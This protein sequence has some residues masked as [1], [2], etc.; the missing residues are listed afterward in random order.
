MVMKRLR[1]YYS[2]VGRVCLST[3]LV[4]VS[5]TIL[6]PAIASADDYAGQTYGDAAQA[7]SKDGKRAVIESRTGNDAANDTCLVTHSQPAPWLKGAYFQPVTD[8][9]LLDL[10]CDAQVA[11]AT[12]SGNSA[13]SPAGQA[14]IAAAKKKAAEQKAAQKTQ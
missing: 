12:K 13:A 8:T 7:I 4:G 10:T 5:L 11:T 14:A 2:T 6:T 1:V 9:V 3:V